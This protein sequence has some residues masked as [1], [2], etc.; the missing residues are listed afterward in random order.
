MVGA[1][2][3]AAGGRET[4]DVWRR[5]GVSRLI[6]RLEAVGEVIGCSPKPNELGIPP[7]DCSD[8]AQDGSQG[9][10]SPCTSFGVFTFRFRCLR[11]WLCS[12]VGPGADQLFFVAF[13]EQIAHGHRLSNASSTS[14]F[15]SD[16][17]SPSLTSPDSG[18]PTPPTP[19]S[20]LPEDEKI[21]SSHPSAHAQAKSHR[22]PVPERVALTSTF[23][24]RELLCIDRASGE[25]RFIEPR[26]PEGI[27][28]RNFGIQVVRTPD[29][30]AVAFGS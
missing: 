27:S 20:S 29:A 18:L 28:L 23:K 14:S 8:L 10:S 15:T 6:A 3:L 21:L 7:R 30:V 11:C 22:S 4:T 9:A 24:P 13:L 1:R 12:P 2:T 25:T 26:V 17:P 19:P 5:R 16:D